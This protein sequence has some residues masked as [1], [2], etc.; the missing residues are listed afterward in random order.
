MNRGATS[1]VKADDLRNQIRGWDPFLAEDSNAFDAAVVMLAALYLGT[2][3]GAARKLAAFTGVPYERTLIFQ[4]RL[5]AAGIWQDGRTVAD[6]DD[7]RSGEAAFWL[8][9]GVADGTF[10]LKKGRTS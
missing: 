6:W 1:Q 5:R 4:R 10:E 3:H 7:P 2:G 9:V 8:D